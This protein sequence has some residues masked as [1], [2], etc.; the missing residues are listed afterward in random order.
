MIS[1]WVD[2]NLLFTF[3][4]ANLHPRPEINVKVNWPHVEKREELGENFFLGKPRSLSLE[5]QD[6]CQ[7]GKL[8]VFLISHMDL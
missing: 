2:V 1:H 6:I 3:C 4:P 5:I 7:N 8:G